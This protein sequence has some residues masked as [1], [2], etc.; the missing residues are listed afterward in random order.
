MSAAVRA[1][2]AVPASPAIRLTKS[3]SATSV[4]KAGD[5]VTYRFVATNSSTFDRRDGLRRLTPSAS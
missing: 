3:A 5:V 4:G 1:V 2:I